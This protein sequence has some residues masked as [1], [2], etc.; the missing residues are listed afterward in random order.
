VD[1][2]I[3]TAV[4]ELFRPSDLEVG[5][6]LLDAEGQELQQRGAP[7][8]RLADAVQNL[9]LLAPGEE[10]ARHRGGRARDHAR[11]V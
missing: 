1:A 9:E 10:R 7:G 3:E 11:G 5:R 4:N 6:H 2:R 8:E